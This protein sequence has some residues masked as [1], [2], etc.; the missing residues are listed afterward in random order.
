MPDHVMQ[1][2]VGDRHQDP[3]QFLIGFCKRRGGLWC[4]AICLRRNVTMA[5]QWWK[6][7][8]ATS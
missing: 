8:L 2:L 1:F 3:L 6:T 5:A 7:A 4:P